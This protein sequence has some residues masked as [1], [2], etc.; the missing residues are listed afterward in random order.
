MK[1]DL[2]LYKG[3]LVLV[4]AS[5]MLLSCKKNNN[6]SQAP[7]QSNL[8]IVNVAPKAGP[9]DITLAGKKLA[10]KLAYGSYSG[11]PGAPYLSVSANAASS[12]K[13]ATGSG[14]VVI[15]DKLKLEANK[16]YSLIVY[17]TLAKTGTSKLL[18]TLLPDDITPPAKGK[19]NIRFFHLSPNTPAVH[20]DIIKDKDS[21]RLTSTP[22]VYLTSATAV[23]EAARFSTINSGTYVIKVKITDSGNKL[24][25][26][27]V[28]PNVVLADQ[29]IFT[30]S[31]KGLSGLTDANTLGIHLIQHK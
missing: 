21:L 7:A 9:L 15:D 25:T 4:C 17:D 6:D 30:I 13:V 2:F 1:K 16:R 14:T 3:L 22:A 12:L 20:I 24:K 18:Y 28:I 29:K 26:I 23:A 8:V 31:L 10:D 5:S 27:L 19:S 11:Q